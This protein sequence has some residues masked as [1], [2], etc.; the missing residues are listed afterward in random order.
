M[1]LGEELGGQQSTGS[2]RSAS[3]ARTLEI[4]GRGT[5]PSSKWQDSGS[6]LDNWKKEGEISTLTAESGF[7]VL[8]RRESGKGWGLSAKLVEAR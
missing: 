8:S 7:H 2:N 4:G 3:A 1:R 5:L 6:Y